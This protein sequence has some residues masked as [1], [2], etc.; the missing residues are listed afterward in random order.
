[1]REPDLVDRISEWVQDHAI[2]TKH[3]LPDT[4]KVAALQGFMDH[5]RVTTHDPSCPAHPDL[6]VLRCECDA[7]STEGAA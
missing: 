7:G 2:Y 1:M 6:A 4:I 5:L 3:D